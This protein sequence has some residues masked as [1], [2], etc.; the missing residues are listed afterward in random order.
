MSTSNVAVLAGESD[1]G[2]LAAVAQALA[3]TIPAVSTPKLNAAGKAAKAAP[4]GDTPVGAAKAKRAAKAPSKAVK[5]NPENGIEGKM[6]TPATV[7]RAPRKAVVV[8]TDKAAGAAKAE[9]GQ[10]QKATDAPPASRTKKAAA[11]VEAPTLQAPG[12]YMDR[13]KHSKIVV[14]VGRKLVNYIAMDSAGLEL[15]KASIDKFAADNTL[16]A[17]YPVEKAAAQYLASTIMKTPQAESM[18]TELAGKAKGKAL[19]SGKVQP[20][21]S[22]HDDKEAAD[23]MVPQKAK[24]KEGAAKKAPTGRAWEHAGKKLVLGDKKPGDTIRAGTLRLALMDAIVACAKKGGV[25]DTVLGMEVMAG[26]PK[27][28]KV[29]VEFAVKN[30]FVKFA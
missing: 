1:K 10:G 14:S 8:P 19:A 9:A 15:R 29:D 3:A 5:V 7:D 17:D 18:L 11:K 22:K 23:A 25:C 13:S 28:A 21:M 20:V 26:K 2:Q 4:K 6:P 27:L 12:V 16:A 24:A 30:G